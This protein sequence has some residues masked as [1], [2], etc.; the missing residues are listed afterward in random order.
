MV[1][2]QFLSK[3]SLYGKFA[4]SQQSTICMSK[5][6]KVERYQS[7]YCSVIQLF[8][9]AEEDRAI[10]CWTVDVKQ[11]PPV[12]DQGTLQGTVARVYNGRS[13]EQKQ[14]NHPSHI[15]YCGI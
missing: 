9:H 12:T 5:F 15:R 13:R 11:L 4:V 7:H 1:R 10:V 3:V 2:L 6:P 8:L 14:L